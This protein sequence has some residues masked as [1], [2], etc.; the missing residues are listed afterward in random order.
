MTL[1]ILL[2]CGNGLQQSPPNPIRVDG[3]YAHSFGD[4]GTTPLI[5]IHDSFG[6]PGVDPSTRSS[7]GPSVNSMYFE[8]GIAQTLGMA[9]QIAAKGYYVIS[10]DLRGQGRSDN[11]RNSSDYTYSQYAKDINSLIAFFNLSHP[12][13]IGHSHGGI[14][15]LK[16]DEMF[17]G[18]ARKIVLVNTPLDVFQMIGSI[19]TS[20]QA[21]YTKPGDAD[22]VTDIKDS[23]KRLS[24][25]DVPHIERAK[26]IAKIFEQAGS[27]GGAAG[28]YTPKAPTIAASKYYLMIS[29]LRVTISNENKTLPIDS[30]LTNEDYIH[31]NEY[32]YVTNHNTTVTN[33]NLQGLIEGI[34]GSED[35]LF[36]ATSLAQIK[37]SLGADTHPERFVMID[38]ASHNVFVDQSATFLA[39]LMTIL[40]P[41]AA[42]PTPTP[43]PPAPAA[44]V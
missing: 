30:F 40:N 29:Q 17:P 20:C 32:A 33:N 12:I 28:L 4:P 16:Y 35:G 22:K 26:N 38:S 31:V 11:A 42:S 36:D 19:S 27:C 15:A 10:Y 21:R 5:F 7:G 37:T 14:I 43:A 1:N 39:A 44:S 2:G 23:L 6:D 41:P 25:P 3:L 13:I 9:A 18:V 24:T 8:F 34:Y